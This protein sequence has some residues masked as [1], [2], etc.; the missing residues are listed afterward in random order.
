MKNGNVAIWQ[1]MFGWWITRYALR[2]LKMPYYHGKEK[3][4]RK[5]II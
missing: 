5:K 4:A 3:R 1:S 2:V